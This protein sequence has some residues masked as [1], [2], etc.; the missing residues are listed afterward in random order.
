MSFYKV[1]MAQIR[2][3]GCEPRKAQQSII[4]GTWQSQIEHSV[5]KT[6][7]GIMIIKILTMRECNGNK[8]YVGRE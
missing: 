2:L 5:H 7:P 3:M 4:P 6:T 8:G 1:A